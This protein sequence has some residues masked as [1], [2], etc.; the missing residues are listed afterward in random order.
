MASLPSQQQAASIY[1]SLLGPVT[2]Y[3]AFNSYATQLESGAKTVESLAAEFL[4]SAKG[5]QLYAGQSNEQIVSQVYER[6][7]GETPSAE[8]ITQLIGTGT[9]AQALASISSNLLNYQ[10]FD[11]ATLTQQVAF[12]SNVNKLLYL[13]PENLAS[14]E[15]R[16]Q[17]VSLALGIAD[18]GVYSISL[19]AWSKSLSEGSSLNY[20]TQKLLAYPEFQRTVGQ[21]EGDALIQQVFTTV[22]GTAATAEQLATYSALPNKQSIIEAIIN[23]LRTSTGTDDTSVT[24]QHAFEARV[25]EN[26]LYKTAAKLSV[27]EGGGNATGTVNTQ[28]SHQLSNAETAVLKNVQLD[29]SSAGNVDLKFADSLSAL[30]I[31][32]SAA[33]TINLSDN[34]ANS[35]VNITTNN[36]N[37]VLNGGSGDDVTTI[38]SAA[39]IATATGTFN[40]GKGDDALIWAGNATTGAN[41]IASTFT[42]NGG[43]GTDSISANFITKNVATTSG[44]L[45]VRSS[46]V[47]TN[48]SQ[49]SGFEKIDLGGYVGKSVGT[50][51]GQAVT[52]GAH[53]FDFGVLNGTSTVEG[54]TGGTI[55][56][57]AQSGLGSLGFALSSKADNVK[58]INAAGGDAAALT[59]TGNATADSNLEITF[60]QNATNKFDIHFDATSTGNIDAGSLSLIS[61]SSVLAGTAL[62]NVNIAS[63]GNGDFTNI[64]NLIG[65]NAQITTLNVTGDNKMDL[66]LGSGY[67][68]V[69]TIDASS[70][71]AGIDLDSAH[72][73]TGDGILVQLLNILPL[74]AVTTTLLTPLL[75]TLGLNGYQLNITGTAADDTFNV[76]AN[77]TITGG[78]GS[79]TYELKGSTSQ[80]G[81]TITDFSSAKDS[82]VDSVSGVTI[83]GDAS[84]SVANYGL[85][86]ADIMDGLL[87]SL[88]G[89][90]TNGVVGLLGGILGLSN[91]NSLTSKVGVASVAFDN[92]TDASYVIID[93]NDNGALDSADSVIYLTN[94][95][96]QNLIDTLHYTE[97]SVNGV[98]NTSSADLAVA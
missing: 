16:E 49:F 90:L 27:T 4:N 28:S 7:Y 42:A 96:H 34:G 29:A 73:G 35:G 11:D 83:A 3:S 56:Q 58:V 21:L 78:A 31:N 51:N 52:T 25:G 92:G 61:S 69:R 38:T 68:N 36:A 13:D 19:E 70:N 81:V 72:A 39:D 74:S 62:A 71:T 77:S 47:T 80:A 95:N 91:S 8:Q 44:L 18:R 85:R 45:G 53:T 5:Q 54:T 41:S 40:L 65:T 63:D 66:T 79:N 97:V 22:H 9:L 93:N 48:A 55:T 2:T 33:A 50:L 82:I 57:T 59:V 60:R 84:S 15:L 64:L 94:Q 37:I 32:G 87:G 89:G 1:Y 43:D 6:V 98:A 75:N 67:S 17:A 20:L 86:S 76:A 12:E 88:V 23:D 26:L 24:Q 30:T 14:Q 46:T 10:G